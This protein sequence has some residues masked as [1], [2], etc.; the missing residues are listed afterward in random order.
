M[1]FLN[2]DTPV[3][4]G[5]E[6]IAQKMKYPIIYVSIHRI[7]RGYYILS[8]DLIQSSQS[9]TKEGEITQ[10]HTRRLERDIIEQPETWLWSHRRWKHSRV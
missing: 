4:M 10:S 9:N 1:S 3:F 5:T 7:K 2:Q 8:A 6:K